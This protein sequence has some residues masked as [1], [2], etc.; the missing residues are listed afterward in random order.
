MSVLQMYE[1]LLEHYEFYK[2]DYDYVL[3]RGRFAFT[4]TEIRLHHKSSSISVTMHEMPIYE[5][6][7]KYAPDLSPVN[8]LRLLHKIHSKAFIKIKNSKLYKL[9]IEALKCYR[10]EY[11]LEGF[12]DFQAGQVYAHSYRER[13]M[14][15]TDNNSLSTYY[16]EVNAVN[17]KVGGCLVNQTL[18]VDANGEIISFETTK[19]KMQI[20]ANS[21]M[22]GLTHHRIFD[23]FL[24][25]DPV[26]D[27]I[28]MSRLTPYFRK[29][30][31]DDILLTL[32]DES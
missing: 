9:H 7:Y 5:G 23:L 11:T 31:I 30:T 13:L 27:S 28:I 17:E 1:H 2:N 25:L 12:R 20:Y 18:Q 6:D 19:T 4:D 15:F 29:R 24:Q 26:A 22:G 32:D 14:T 16:L 10:G 8:V 3:L 21:V